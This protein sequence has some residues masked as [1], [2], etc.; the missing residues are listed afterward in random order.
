MPCFCPTCKSKVP[1]V[2]SICCDCCDKWFHLECTEIT[3]AQFKVFTTDGSFVWFCNKC[4][5]DTCNKCNILTRH[6]PKLNCAK[7]NKHYHL[8][9]AGLSKK[10]EIPYGI[11]WYCYQ[12]N[13][14]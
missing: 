8:R 5:I 10:A 4:T 9:C 12:C 3:R 1:N 2:D 13:S 14:I 7:C 11:P 6:G